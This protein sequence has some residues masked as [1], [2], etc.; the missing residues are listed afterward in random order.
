MPRILRRGMGY[1]PSASEAPAQAERGILFMAY[2]AS[3]AEQFETV[4]RWIAGGNSTGVGSAQSDPLLGVPREGEPRVFRWVGA[5]GSPQRA[6]LGS[7]AFV[8]LQWGLYLFVPALPAL[9]RLA[10]FRTAPPPLPSA[11]VPAATEL[12]CWR[13]RLEDRDS[14]RVTWAKVREQH[15]GVVDAPSYGRLLGSADKVFEALADEACAKVSVQGFGERMGASVGLNHLGQDPAEGHTAV[16]AV[17]NPVV[18]A[19]D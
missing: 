12:D 10:D 1:G 5:D 13:A 6:D 16:G 3:I 7:R 9:Q 8:E 19:I 4:Q 18:A 11:H 15:G 14:G 2:C 17:V